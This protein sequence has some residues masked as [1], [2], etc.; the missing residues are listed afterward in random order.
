LTERALPDA[1]GLRAWRAGAAANPTGLEQSRRRAGDQL[2]PSDIIAFYIDAAGAR[3]LEAAIMRNARRVHGQV[4]R[5]GAVTIV[6]A[7]APAAGCAAPS[8]RAC[9]AE[10]ESAF[11]RSGHVCA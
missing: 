4:A 11:S 10:V 8:R 7:R 5:R 3:R 1:E 9:F 2:Y 6:W